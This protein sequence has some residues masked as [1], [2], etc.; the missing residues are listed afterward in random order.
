MRRLRGQALALGAVAMVVL[1]LATLVTVHVGYGI[2]ERLRLQSTADAAAYSMA[3][4][5]ARAFNLYAF[6]NR[7]QASHYVSAMMFHSLV[8]FLY[9]NEAFLTDAY[10]MMLTLNPC[11]GSR[12]LFWK[13]A[14]PIL[15]AMP[16]IGPLIGALSKILGVFRNLVRAY[17]QALRATNVDAVV[18]RG[19]IPGLRTLSIGLASVST[20][21]MESALAEARSTTDEIVS[22]ND[23]DLDASRSRALTGGLSACLFDRAHYRE[24]NGSPLQPNEHPSAPLRPL[25]R[26]ESSKV[27]RAKRVMAG[28]ANGTRYACDSSARCPETFITR[29]K[30]GDLISVPGWLGPVKDF[31]NAAPKLGQTRLLTFDLAKGYVDR[32]QGGNFIRDPDD[33]PDHPMAMLAQGDNLGADDTYELGL[34]GRFGRFANPFKCDSDTYRYWECWGEPR[35]N[36]LNR[37]GE[38]PYRFMMKTSVWATNNDETQIRRGGV[39]WRLAHE[40]GYPRGRGQREPNAPGA[41]EREVG[42]NQYVKHV[43]GIPVPMYVANVREIEDGNHPWPGIIAFPHFEPGDYATACRPAADRGVDPSMTRSAQRASDFNQ[44]STWV[45]LNKP[46]P[47][48]QNLRDRSGAGRLGPARL[49]GVFN[50]AFTRD[51]RGVDLEDDRKAFLALGAEPGLN[52]ISRGQVYYHRPGNWAEQPNFFN[53]YWR[54]RLASVLQGRGQASLVENLIDALPLALRA[55]PQK[56]LVH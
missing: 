49:G 25:D 29:R 44:P 35:R 36:H 22:A 11:G 5:E 37:D 8:S 50:V 47:A 27:A 39:H 26:K 20:Q 23:P 31:L 16:G 12:D 55:T 38:R 41:S 21:V 2:H 4:T 9:F 28:I 48:L 19:I 54:P 17:Q 18:G 53:P 43:A 40:G 32:D 51:S 7:T 13:A 15:Q 30:L 1:A 24:S 14:C 52:A 42:L 6:A 46:A 10:G 3:A 34:G 45:A 56:A 33:T